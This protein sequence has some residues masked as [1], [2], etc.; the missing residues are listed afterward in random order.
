MHLHRRQFV[1][2][3]EPVSPNSN[4]QHV[5]IGGRTV[6]YCPDLEAHAATDA[7]GCP[8]LL[9]GP[10]VSTAK[11]YATPAA[12]ISATRTKAVPAA[13]ADWAGRFVLIGERELIPD[14]TALLGVFVGADDD[15]RPVVSSSPALIRTVGR[16]TPR[17]I[18][19]ERT[20]SHG[21]GFSWLPPPSSRYTDVKRLLASQ[22][23]SLADG[24]VAARPLLVPTGG[25]SDEERL[26]AAI[27][28]LSRAIRRLSDANGALHLGLSAGNDSRFVL[29]LAA[30]SGA[31]V[32]TFTIREPHRSVADRLLPPDIARRAGVAHRYLDPDPGRMTTAERHRRIALL[33]AHSADGVAGRETTAF[34]DGIRDQLSGTMI[35]GG[36]FALV[37]GFPPLQPLPGEMPSRARAMRLLCK[38]FGED[39]TS[40]SADA[41]S[42]WLDWMIA[43][44]EPGLDW[45][46]RWFFEQRRGGWQSAKEQVYD[47]QDLR[48]VAVL[49][50]TRIWSLF[51][52]LPRDMRRDGSLYRRVI[53]ATT[54]ALNRVPA[55]PS[56]QSFVFR[57]PDLVIRRRIAVIRRNRQT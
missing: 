43:H 40:A 30:A 13:S 6:S 18:A 29:S 37:T 12:Q 56:D 32:R 31:N 48:R 22:R 36:G 49:N 5:E 7:E 42:H 1:I 19:D 14:A 20:L 55:N 35:N 44:P 23:L 10:V 16:E 51:L 21:K 2:W 34:T 3:Q 15:G 57:R 47:L 28:G 52:G 50:S 24:T 27:E 54:P 11:E 25:L 33:Q 26:T 53:E 4:W 46:D 41:M 45:R 8:W 17:R 38:A 9:L 39:P